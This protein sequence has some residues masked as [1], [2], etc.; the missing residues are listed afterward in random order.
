MPEEQKPVEEKA[1]DE[2]LHTACQKIECKQCSI[3][4]GAD[5]YS[6]EGNPQ[7]KIMIIGQSMTVDDTKNKRVF[8]GKIGTY[9]NYVLAKA[10]VLRADVYV[11]NTVKGFVKPGSTVPSPSIKKCFQHLR[12]EITAL[13]PQVIVLL[14]ASAYKNFQ[15]TAVA[16]TQYYD[17]TFQCWV[18][19]THHLMKQ[20]YTG[21]PQIEVDIIAT[22]RKAKEITTGQR[23]MTTLQAPS[24]TVIRTVQE[25]EAHLPSMLSCK[26]WGL[27]CETS[28]LNIGL[29]G[30]LTIGLSNNIQ[31]FGIIVRPEMK[32]LLTKLLS[33]ISI[34]GQHTKF[35]VQMLWKLMGFKVKVSFDDMLAHSIIDPLGPHNL[36]AMSLKYLGTSFTKDVDYEQLYANGITEEVLEILVTRGAYDAYLHYALHLIF[37]PKIEELQSHRFYYDVLLPIS[38]LLTE[39]EFNGI[40]VDLEKL[41]EVEVSLDYQLK[42]VEVDFFKDPTIQAFLKKFKLE[43]L[44]FRSPKQMSQLLYDFLRIPKD[45]HGKQTTDREYLT[46]VNE[47]LQNPVIDK[48]LQFRNL[49]KLRDTYA[50]GIRRAVEASPT[51]RI[52]VD[53]HQC[54]TITGRISCSNPNLQTIPKIVGSANDI[55]QVFVSAPG[56]TIV[57]MDFK[58]LEFRVWAHLSRDVNMI[59]MIAAGGDIHVQVAAS[60]FNKLEKDV[61]EEE[62]YMAK[63]L[64]FGLIYGRG[65]KSVSQQFK[66]TLDRAKVIKDDFF[67]AF[68]AATLWLQQAGEFGVK[69]RYVKTPFGSIIPIHYNPSDDNSIAAAKRHAVNYP[70]QGSAAYLTNM[71][72]VFALRKVKEQK[73]DCKVL[74]NVHDALYWE[75]R[76]EQIPQLQTI[77]EEAIEEIRQF[78]SCRVPLEVDF[79]KGLSLAVQEKFKTVHSTKEV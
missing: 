25:L 18:L 65:I 67:R 76:E 45:E 62:R 35:D 49:A 68:P 72:G 15:S 33:E 56:Y 13:K 4:K 8:T 54:G 40:Q 39:M 47:E 48:L 75:I 57:E 66:I 3:G 63:Y 27:D 69:N 36:D 71:T 59:K 19:Y 7:A 31:T 9:L 44:N 73:L 22:F 26:E 60:V 20:I 46:Y 16:G 28:G 51:G 78:I 37:K 2:I 21:D 24:V 58:Q 5:C 74:L 79:K 12:E 70:V 17:E 41:Y 23:D 64:D 32:E 10:G 61:T 14:G 6:G 77:V 55:R 53:Y 50:K 43:T 42:A 1:W 52:H 29:H 38:D 30:V 34:V 11:T